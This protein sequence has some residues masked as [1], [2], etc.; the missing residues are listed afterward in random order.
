MT[1][2]EHLRE[3][4]KAAW[5]LALL[6]AFHVLHGLV[7]HE[8]TSHRFWGLSVLLALALAGGCASTAS[9]VSPCVREAQVVE[10]KVPVS[11]PVVVPEELQWPDP[12]SY[13]P[14]PE[15]GCSE[16]ELKAWATETARVAMERE[17][18]LA[19][20]LEACLGYLNELGES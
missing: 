13:P 10:V 8:W 6:A 17:R 12:P 9:D 2:V 11:Q 20:M 14:W 18:A 4:L 1:Y 5:R 19:G 3:N 15:N 16:A 7:R